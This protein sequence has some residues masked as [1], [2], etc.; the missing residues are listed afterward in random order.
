MYEKINTLEEYAN[1]PLWQ[2]EN[3][4]D[5]VVFEISNENHLDHWK[6]LGSFAPS[7][8]KRFHTMKAVRGTAR[9]E[10]GA[11][12]VVL[13]VYIS[14]RALFE[15]KPNIEMYITQGGRIVTRCGLPWSAITM[16][17]ISNDEGTEVSLDQDRF[18]PPQAPAGG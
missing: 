7:I 5:H 13:C 16:I 2:G 6:R 4:P 1:H 10:F 15:L 3:P 12:Y 14:V 18:P 8:T 11:K 9:Q 17:R